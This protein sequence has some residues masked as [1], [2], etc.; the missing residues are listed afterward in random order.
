MASTVA[1]AGPPASVNC[2]AAR[3]TATR[4]RA[5][6]GLPL[7]PGCT[8]WFAVSPCVPSFMDTMSSILL[9][10]AVQP[11]PTGTAMKGSGQASADAIAHLRTRDS[12]NRGGRRGHGHRLHRDEFHLI[13]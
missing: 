13:G 7:R 4:T 10:S 2:A 8:V 1:A 3:T 12:H 5:L 6:R 9:S 11:S